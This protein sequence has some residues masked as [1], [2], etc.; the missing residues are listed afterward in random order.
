MEPIPTGTVIGGRY[1]VVASIG[2]GAMGAVYRVEDAENNESRALKLLHADLSRHPEIIARF[3]REAIAA[4]RIEHPNV[5]HATDFGCT[6]DGSFYL[7][8]EFVDG[9]DLRSELRSGPMDAARAI[10]VMRGV[11][12]GVR[13]AHEKG[14]IH[15]DLKPE[16]IML[17]EHEDNRDFV[18]LLDFGI[19][20]LESGNN[21][22]QRSMQA[23]TIAG[24]PLGTPEYMSPEQVLGKPVDART[25]L[26]AIGVIMFELLAGTCPF[27]GKIPKLLQQHLTAQPP[28]LPPA[29]AAGHPDL[30]RV[31]RILLAK[32][33]KNRFQSAA[34]LA[35]ALNASAAG[36]ARPARAPDPPQ[37]ESRTLAS[38]AM[39]AS[40]AKKRLVG[41][42][43]PPTRRSARRTVSIA[44]ACCAALLLAA[45]LFVMKRDRTTPASDDAADPSD[46]ASADPRR[47][48]SPAQ[49][50]ATGE[51]GKGTPAK[52]RRKLSEGAAPV[53][54][55]TK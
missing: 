6:A 26:Y 20:R 28:D 23:L 40:L 17:V 5:V 18:K 50:S 36:K 14:I 47:A 49:P 29:V 4:S 52:S 16:N 19:A 42:V 30:A 43:A 24:R 34:E 37:A 11:V 51:A 41:I 53:K 9:R 1:R 39:R 33:P 25:D 55:K 22:P 38:L 12:A 32:E 46:A 15:R 45:L 54:S 44:V 7:V 31:V 8:L 21:N 3:E 48:D 10:N 35:E 27:D 2:E 13:A